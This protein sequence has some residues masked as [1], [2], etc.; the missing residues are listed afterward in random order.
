MGMIVNPFG[1]FASGGGGSPVGLVQVIG[2]QV[3]LGN[4]SPVTFNPGTA[5]TPG[6]TVIMSFVAFSDNG[7]DPPTD[8]TATVNGSAMTCHVSTTNNGDQFVG[9]I[10]SGVAGASGGINLS[11]AADTYSGGG[12]YFAISLMER[13]DITGVDTSM[14]RF[15][16]RASAG[17]AGTPLTITSGALASGNEIIFILGMTANAVVTNI[18]LQGGDTA[19]YQDNDGNNSFPSTFAYRANTGTGAQTATWTP[20]QVGDWGM[21]IVGFTK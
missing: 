7:F 9:A 11:F 8:L 4:A 20:D 17:G 16:T 3:Y 6:N 21:M 1:S 15:A 14:I 12:N 19:I 2:E 10:L 18:T 13:D 5:F